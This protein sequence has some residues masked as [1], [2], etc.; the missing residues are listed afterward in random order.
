[1]VQQAVRRCPSPFKVQDSVSAKDTELGNF[2]INFNEKYGA[3]ML[4]RWRRNADANA[5]GYQLWF[6]VR[7]GE[8]TFSSNILD[9]DYAHL[10]ITDVETELEALVI[11]PECGITVT[12]KG[13]TILYALYPS[14][15]QTSVELLM[16]PR[17]DI[18]CLMLGTDDWY[19]ANNRDWQKVED[20]KLNGRGCRW[21]STP[22]LIDD[23]R[24]PLHAR[25]YC[26]AFDT[27]DMI[28]NHFRT[29]TRCP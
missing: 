17:F 4:L 27:L 3:E 25:L 2:C 20:G 23:V 13:I 16:T 10:G 12:T 24:Q 9:I 11:F 28:T 6:G 19:Q 14:L 8:I 22:N 26:T 18:D 5:T 21:L 7:Q 15:A 1:M 29:F